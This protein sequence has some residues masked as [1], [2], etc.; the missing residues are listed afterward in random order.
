M[1]IERQRMTRREAIRRFRPGRPAMDSEPVNEMDRQ[2]REKSVAAIALT[3]TLGDYQRLYGLYDI[4]LAEH[5]DFL[6]W[7]RGRFNKKGVPEDGHVRKELHFAADGQQDDD[8]KD[9]FHLNNSLEARWL[10]AGRGRFSADVEL[11]META[12]AM[13]HETIDVTRA[14][15]KELSDPDHEGAYVGM[16]EAYHPSNLFL[17]TQRLIRY[18]PYIDLGIDYDLAK[19][20]TD[21]GGVTIQENATGPGLYR[22]LLG[23][24]GPQ[25]DKFPV[26]WENGQSQVFFGQAHEAVYGTVNNPIRALSHGVLAQP[27]AGYRYTTVSFN[28]MPLADL[29]ITSRETQVSRTD[30]EN[31][32]V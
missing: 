20:H 7:S 32:N 21:K 11:F 5:P 28:D 9:I 8:P 17:V 23:Q 24:V 30:D 3:N 18:D 12:R 25:F 2:L 15:I 27:G 19:I 29:K 14:M 6:A 26:P 13:R 10:E 31:L 22:Q 1:L 4:V 16:D